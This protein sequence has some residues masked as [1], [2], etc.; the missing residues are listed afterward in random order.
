[1]QMCLRGGQGTE[2]LFGV[3]CHKKSEPPIIDSPVQKYQNNYLDPRNKNHC[4][5]WN[6]G[7]P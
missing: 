1:M 6:F 3:A 4:N 2:N 5:I 7:P